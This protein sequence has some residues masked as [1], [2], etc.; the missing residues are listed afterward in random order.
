MIKERYFKLEDSGW[1]SMSSDQ[2]SGDLKYTATEV[3]IA[4]Y[5]LKEEGSSNME[6][7]DSICKT[8][9][10]E[11][12]VEFQFEHV[13]QKDLLQSEFTSK[14]YESSVKYMAFSMEK[15][16]SVITSKQ[17]TIT[18]SGVVF[19]RNFKVAPFKRVLLFFSGI[20]PN[21]PI[22]LM[23]RDH[24]YKQGLF[25]FNFGEQPIKL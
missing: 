5:V 18:C 25:H 23:Y 4:Y 3:P 22:I 17:D 13:E 19:E 20:E 14:D 2:F 21:T 10:K 1:R 24:L 8:L 7:V 15:D 9:E 12:I 6:K 11:R 16:F